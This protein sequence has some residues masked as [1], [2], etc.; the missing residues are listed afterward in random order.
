MP[1]PKCGGTMGSMSDSCLECDYEEPGLDFTALG[2][3][4]LAVIAAPVIFIA[5]SRGASTFHCVGLGVAMVAAFG[6]GYT[7]RRR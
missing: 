2:A 1:C 3:F 5:D 4:A 6:I 7:C